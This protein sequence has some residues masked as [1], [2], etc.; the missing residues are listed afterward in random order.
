MRSFNE[1][2]EEFMSADFGL[3]TVSSLIACMRLQRKNLSNDQM[4]NLLEIPI[5]V[6]SND[7]VLKN[8]KEFQAEA[9]YFYGNIG[10][11]A[12]D[13]EYLQSFISRMNAGELTLNDMISYT[14]YIQDNPPLHES[15]FLLRNTEVTI[16]D[17]VQL[18]SLNNFRRSGRVFANLIDRIIGI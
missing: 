1:I 13:H 11:L 9:N 5:D 10:S 14:K 15:D 16:R 4:K 18:S 6:L 7:V 12:R 3:D 8:D 17:F 2:S